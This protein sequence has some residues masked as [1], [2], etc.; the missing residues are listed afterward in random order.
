MLMLRKHWNWLHTYLYRCGASSKDYLGFQGL[1]RVKI[2]LTETKTE[3]KFKI[4]TVLRVFLVGTY[5]YIHRYIYVIFYYNVLLT[6][7]ILLLC[8][9]LCYVIAA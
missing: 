6:C 8:I 2:G 1:S 7:Y 9:I 5:T 4:A 3:T